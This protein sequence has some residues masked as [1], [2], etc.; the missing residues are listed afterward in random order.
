[1]RVIVTGGRD[2]A[3]PWVVDKWMTELRL[4]MGS[5]LERIVV[6]HGAARG[7]DRMAH[8]LARRHGF[9]PEAHP[10]DWERY[11]KA[12]GPIRNAVMVSAPTPVSAG[13][14]ASTCCCDMAGPRTASTSPCG[15]GSRSR[16]STRRATP[17]WSPSRRGGSDEGLTAGVS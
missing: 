5:P 16:C 15:P 12:A 17:T 9:T 10:A 8:A 6:V 1:M 13:R 11:G 14:T 2:W 4:T 3:C 7:L